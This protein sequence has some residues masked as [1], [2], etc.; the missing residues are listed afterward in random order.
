[1]G[2]SCLAGEYSTQ[3]EKGEEGG[4]LVQASIKAQILKN[5]Y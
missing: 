1:M 3:S 4:Y 2:T 5:I